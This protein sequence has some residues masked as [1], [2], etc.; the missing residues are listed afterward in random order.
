MEKEVFVL[1]C[2]VDGKTIAEKVIKEMTADEL[3]PLEKLE[4][5]ISREYDMEFLDDE[6]IGKVH[7]IE[8]QIANNKRA[9]REVELKDSWEDIKSNILELEKYKDKG[10]FCKYA[11]HED[12]CLWGQ[13]Y[14]IFD[15]DDY[16]FV[17]F[18]RVI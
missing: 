8:E 17:D 16:N 13:G 11:V 9:L 1:S 2:K 7:S 18:I 10:L 3:T 5:Y 14:V 6:I 4:N 12:S 15:Q